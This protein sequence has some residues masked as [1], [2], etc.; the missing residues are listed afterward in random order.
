MRLY[1][2]RAELIKSIMVQQDK[3][4]HQIRSNEQD[5]KKEIVTLKKSQL[6]LLNEKNGLAQQL[7]D[8]K[9]T[10]NEMEIAM[11]DAAHSKLELQ[12]RCNDL[13]EQCE[14]ERKQK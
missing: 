2:N 13:T 4:L 9:Q 8:I 6:D 5:L 11:Q 14:N 12:N 7:L 10:V 1:S 3:L